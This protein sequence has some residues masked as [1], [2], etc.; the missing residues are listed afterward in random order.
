[1]NTYSLIA[2]DG[3]AYGPVDENGLVR[4]ARERR[5]APSSQIRSTETGAVI[6]AGSLPFLTAIFNPP[7]SA[8]LPP[9]PGTVAVPSASL[10]EMPVAAVVLLH[11]F[12]CGIFSLI[13]F[14]LVHGRLPKIRPDDPS[15]GKAI[16]FMFIPFF[17]LYWVFFS[18]LRLCD[19]ID[20]QRALYGLR[21]SNLRGFAITMCVILLIPYINIL[22]GLII[23]PIFFGM[24]Q[25][26]INELVAASSRSSALATV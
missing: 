3:Q 5:I 19:R 6:A 23:N 21:P 4:W 14:G 22:G 10:T 24:M 13:W 20:E 26:S 16:G 7:P 15:A 1:M 8:T 18:Y 12:T 9:M 17:N 2:P 11:F 25:S